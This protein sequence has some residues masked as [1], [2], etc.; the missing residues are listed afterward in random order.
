M[1]LYTLCWSGPFRTATWGYDANGDKVTR[2]KTSLKHMA[3]M[4]AYKA[5]QALYLALSH[6]SA[7][8][9]FKARKEKEPGANFRTRQR[10]DLAK[11]L[12]RK[13]VL[14]TCH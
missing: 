13:R 4:A 5:V 7:H 6:P 3:Q 2:D 9:K 12:F 1:L 8:S 14:R 10:N 11:Q